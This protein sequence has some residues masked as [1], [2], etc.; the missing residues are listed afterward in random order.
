MSIIGH[1]SRTLPRLGALVGITL[2]FA[3]MAC[4]G[5][6][7]DGTYKGTQTPVRSNTGYYH[8]W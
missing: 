7:F 5:G 1:R 2:A 4:A 3:G 8:C 6:S